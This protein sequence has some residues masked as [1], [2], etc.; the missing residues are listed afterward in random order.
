MAISDELLVFVP[1]EFAKEEELTLRGTGWSRGLHRPSKS[2]RAAESLVAL[3]FQQVS[4]SQQNQTQVRARP[5]CGNANP[6]KVRH[7]SR[8]HRPREKEKLK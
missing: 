3:L 7:V 1:Y 4:K 5:L 6:S 2:R 8:N